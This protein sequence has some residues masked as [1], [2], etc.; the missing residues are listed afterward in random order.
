MRDIKTNA[1]KQPLLL[2][3]LFVGL[4]VQAQV[5]QQINYQGVA[6]NSV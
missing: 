1:M 3:L 4:N 2:L 5:P 6:R